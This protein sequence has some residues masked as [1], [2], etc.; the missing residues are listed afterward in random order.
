MKVMTLGLSG[1]ILCFL[2]RC[3]LVKLVVT[4]WGSMED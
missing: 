2:C 3:E 4:H 1:N